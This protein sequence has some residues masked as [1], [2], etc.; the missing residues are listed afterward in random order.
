MKK[1]VGNR[2]D[3]EKWDDAVNDS[4]LPTNLMGTRVLP[5]DKFGG[6]LKNTEKNHEI[7]KAHHNKKRYV[8]AHTYLLFP[9][10][11]FLYTG[12]SFA[13]SMFTANF[14]CECSMA[15]PF[16]I[17]I[18]QGPVPN[19]KEVEDFWPSPPHPFS[20]SFFQEVRASPY[21]LK[22]CFQIS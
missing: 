10:S 11:I 14:S 7:I 3:S 2:K 15:L 19:L 5:G 6:N 17:S 16:A 4:H 20:C 1:A 12:F 21:I 13:V 22:L 9:S 8:K 18:I